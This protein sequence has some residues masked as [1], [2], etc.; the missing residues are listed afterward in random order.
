[1]QVAARQQGLEGR[2]TRLKVGL[3]H[4]RVAKGGDARQPHHDGGGGRAGGRASVRI[5]W[6]LSAWAGQA[7]IDT[8]VG[9]IEGFDGVD[10]VQIGIVYIGHRGVGAHGNID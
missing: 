6:A 5:R 2:G 1:M 4:H 8:Q 3:G 9:G 10:P 7:A